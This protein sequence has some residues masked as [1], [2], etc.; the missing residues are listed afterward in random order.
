MPELPHCA[1]AISM[2]PSTTGQRDSPQGERTAG[3]GAAGRV[4]TA[5][6]RRRKSSGAGAGRE[7]SS[8]GGF[9]P[10]TRL[11]HRSKNVRLNLFLASKCVKETHNFIIL[12][13]SS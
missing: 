8:A 1:T 9:S 13:L 12:F 7:A 4:W 11:A 6:P 5:W 10:L 3:R 2:T